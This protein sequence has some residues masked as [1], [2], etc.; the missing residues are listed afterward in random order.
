[1]IVRNVASLA[2][3]TP[4]KMGKRSLAAGAYVYAGLNSFEAGQEH[5]A[6]TH[7]DQDKLYFVIEGEGEAMV[8]D[9]A[10]P[11]SAGDLI[12]APAGVLHSM[13]NPGPGRLTVLVVF[14]PPPTK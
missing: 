12:L 13:H 14:G 10:G 8:G 11:V 6:H 9:E 3:F 7:A 2:E 1:M 4:E 5:K